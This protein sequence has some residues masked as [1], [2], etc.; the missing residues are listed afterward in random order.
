MWDNWT[1][2]IRFGPNLNSTLL[3]DSEPEIELQIQ[4]DHTRVRRQR[5]HNSFLR[6]WPR[7]CILCMSRQ[8]G[9]GDKLSK[10]YILESIY[11]DHTT[12]S[13]HPIENWYT[14]MQLLAVCC[15]PYPYN[16]C[17][18]LFNHLHSFTRSSL[19][20]GCQLLVSLE[21]IPWRWVESTW[22]ELLAVGVNL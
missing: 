18:V 5:P 9:S 8:K 10:Y 7:F 19:F 3:S 20:Q 4:D 17:H 1:V 16:V 13:L 15:Y 14:Y 21:K 6:T 22:D 12:L 2:N 11:Y